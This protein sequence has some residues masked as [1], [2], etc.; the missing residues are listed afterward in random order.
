MGSVYVAQK[1]TRI[2][3]ERAADG[4]TL[5]LAARNLPREFRAMIIEAQRLQ[6]VVNRERVFR[7]MRRDFDIL[8]NRE[9]RHQIVEL[10]HEAKLASTVFANRLLAEG[11]DG[12]AAYFDRTPHRPLQGRR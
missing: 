8:P 10:E 2:L 5:L 7:K 1:Q 6:K 11:R 3:H 4:A 12:G 9:V